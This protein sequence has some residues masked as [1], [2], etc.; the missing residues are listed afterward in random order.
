MGGHSAGSRILNGILALFFPPISVA[1]V[2]G[3]GT[4]GA[5]QVLIN[6]VLWVCFWLPACV[7][8]WY[9][10][11]HYRNGFYEN[12]DKKVV[13]IQ[14]SQPPPG[15][16]HGQGPAGHPASA[17]QPQPQ[18]QSQVQPPANQ[19]YSLPTYNESQHTGTTVDHGRPVDS[20]K[21][22]E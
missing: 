3:C 9:I 18:P 21:K 8:A 6:L 19:E 10:I 11:H 5:V 17:P 13:Y 15:H 4:K 2:T 22:K 7:H 1:I 16:E 14:G 12:D 20:A